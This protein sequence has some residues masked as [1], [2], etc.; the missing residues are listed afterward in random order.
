MAAISVVA[1]NGRQIVNRCRGQFG[2]AVGIEQAK[3]V[4]GIRAARVPVQQLVEICGADSGL[5]GI[6]QGVEDRFRLNG[7]VDAEI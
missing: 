1:Q 2:R 5:V 6:D 4:L 7:L 3:M